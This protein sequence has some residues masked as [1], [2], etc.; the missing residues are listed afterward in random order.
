MKNTNVHLQWAKLDLIKPQAIVT[1]FGRRGSGKSTAGK[2]YARLLA[3]HIDRFLIMCGN[4]DT[5]GD[6]DNV[7]DPMFI[8]LM[9]RE[10]LAELIKFQD[11]EVSAL[12]EAYKRAHEGSSEGF[13][14][15]RKNRVAVIIDDCGYEST[16]MNCI[17]M[18]DITANGR[19]YGMDV[20]IMCQYFNQLN[21]K[22]RNQIDYL[23]L[24]F[25]DNEKQDKKV[26]EEYLS[27]TCKT[28]KDFQAVFEVCTQKKGQ[29]CWIDNTVTTCNPSEKIFMAKIPHPD[30]WPKGR[31]HTGM[32]EQYT[33]MYS[34]E[35]D[36]YRN[37]EDLQRQMNARQTVYTTARDQQLR[38]HHPVTEI[39]SVAP[40]ALSSVAPSVHPPRPPPT[41]DQTVRP[42]PQGLP[43]GYGQPVHGVQHG[44]T[45]GYG[46]TPQGPTHHLPQ[47]F[48]QSTQHLP[49][50]FRQSTHN[51]PQGY[52]QSAQYIP[53][54]Y[55]QSA[56]HLPQGFDRSAQGY[57][58]GDRHVYG[59]S[60][61]GVP[62]GLPQG[63]G[64]GYGQ[65][66]QGASQGGD[67]PR[68]V[69]GYYGVGRIGVRFGAEMGESF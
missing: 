54:G 63:Y 17:E 67:E 27:K 57:Q 64:Q 52:D 11:N 7:V 28:L 33:T 10:K 49:Q 51:L 31:I 68:G 14:I 34:V 60:V 19:H 13:V 9:N 56:Q 4:K 35:S 29:M 30:T 15:P 2:Y 6:W 42:V 18:M 69:P 22:N 37:N 5:A 43:R 45:Q 21:P 20:V 66:M 41:Y 65:S 48:H 16:F 39:G 32:C 40:Y 59:P 55:G 24:M 8:H 26:Y 50:G 3:R 25:T 1:L 44:Y 61:Q 53:Q 62:Q 36:L 23:G 46:H 38:V 12:R 58:H 47:G